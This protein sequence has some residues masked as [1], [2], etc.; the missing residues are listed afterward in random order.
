MQ[1]KEWLLSEE[2]VFQTEKGSI[3][4]FDGQKSVRYKTPHDF[5]DKKD[6]GIKQQSE[7]TVFVDPEVSREIGMWGTVSSSKNV[8]Y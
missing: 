2:I 1:Y 5:H 4:R 8:L 7:I 3:Y 6:T